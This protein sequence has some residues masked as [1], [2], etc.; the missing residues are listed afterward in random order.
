MLNRFGISNTSLCSFCNIEDE[1]PLHLFYGCL[2][3]QDLWK[4]LQDYLKQDIVLPHLIPQSA[5]FGFLD[6]QQKEYILIN[7]LLIIFK[8][9]VY[10]TSRKEK[11]KMSLQALLSNIIQ[12]KNI[13]EKLSKDNTWKRE[14]FIKKWESIKLQ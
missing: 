5:I 7:H 4:E 14:K 9:Y 2:K 6:I 13:E 1:T 10:S 3:T 11:K 8:F 12:I